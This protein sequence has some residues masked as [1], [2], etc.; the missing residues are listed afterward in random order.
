MYG[1]MLQDPALLRAL[2]QSAQMVQVVQ[3]CH[4]QDACI[5]SSTG[6]WLNCIPI[7]FGCLLEPS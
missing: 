7:M 1:K 4:I 3:L 2:Q 6:N 5:T